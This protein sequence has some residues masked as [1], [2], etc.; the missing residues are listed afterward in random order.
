MQASS[1]FGL[2]IWG[3][4][5]DAT[6]EAHAAKTLLQEWRPDLVIT[7][8]FSEQLDMLVGGESSTPHVWMSCCCNK[9]YLLK[10]PET[11][12]KH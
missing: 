2:P 7:N 5:S 10:M 3:I 9:R 11:P 8:C 4:V 12:T 1:K 6:E